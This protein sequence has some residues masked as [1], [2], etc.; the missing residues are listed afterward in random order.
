MMARNRPRIFE[1]L[2]S[3]RKLQSAT[4]EELSVLDSAFKRELRIMDINS[5]LILLAPT[6]L[7]FT[8]FLTE[9]L[10]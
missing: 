5:L 2:A 8:N 3:L 6:E 10:K 7:I 1:R 9:R 4:G